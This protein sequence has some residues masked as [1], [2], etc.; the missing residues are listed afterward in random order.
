[1]GWKL[2]RL[3]PFELEV[4][5][6]LW[7]LGEASVREVQAALAPGRRPAYTTVQ[8]I[9][10]RLEEKGAVRRTRKVGNATL[11]EA[12]LARAPVLG[13]LLDELVTLFGGSQ[14]LVSHLMETGRLDLADLHALEEA[15][16]AAGSD[17]GRESAD[18]APVP[19]RSRGKRGGR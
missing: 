19:R 7:R 5:Q 8:T 6:V 14:P 17:D 10:A 1:V 4:M 3:S 18:A 12:K 16:A 15:R 11:F 2:P 9:V 13:R